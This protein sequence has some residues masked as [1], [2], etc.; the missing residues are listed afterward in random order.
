LFVVDPRPCF[1]ISLST[2]GSSNQKGLLRFG[3]AA[4]GGLMGLLALVYAFPN[5]QGLG[6][7]WLV[8]GAGPRWP[9]GS[10][11]APPGSPAA[12]LRSGSPSTRRRSRAS[13]PR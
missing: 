9:R 5:V 11:S 8:F 3:G 1:V 13:G 12:D 10:T 6:G 7:F 4:V 2:I